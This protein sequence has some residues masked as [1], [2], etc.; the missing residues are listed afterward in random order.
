MGLHAL[1]LIE[2][3]ILECSEVLFSSLFSFPAT[4]LN[5]LGLAVR[6]WWV[7]LSKPNRFAKPLSC[8]FLKDVL[9]SLR[10][11]EK[12]F[13]IMD[14]C[15]KC[16]HYL[17]F[18]REMAEEDGKAMDEIEEMGKL[19]ARYLRGEVSKKELR[20]RFFECMHGESK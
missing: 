2:G 12:V 9:C 10:R 8:L 19:H 14:R 3:S 4:F 17:R 20:R 16:P 15:L 18:L 7:G 6:G 1:C 13:G 11:S 5:C